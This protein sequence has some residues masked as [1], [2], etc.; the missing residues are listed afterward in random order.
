MRRDGSRNGRKRPAPFAR[1]RLRRCNPFTQEGRGE[2]LRFGDALHFDR[3]R[4]NR[5]LEAMEVVCRDARERL[6][7]LHA[8]REP[9]Q[10]PRAKRD[11]GKCGRHRD[12]NDCHLREQ[13]RIQLRRALL[14]SAGLPPYGVR[15]HKVARQSQAE[16][17]YKPRCGLPPKFTSVGEAQCGEIWQKLVSRH[18]QFVF[19][20]NGYVLNSGIGHVQ[21]QG[22]GDRTVHQLLVNYQCGVTPDRKNGGGGFLR[23]LEVEADGTVNVSDYSPFYDQWLT[24]PD[25]KFTIRLDRNLNTAP[26]A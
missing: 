20:F 8:A 11:A 3:N 14:S 4:V 18:P 1:I 16:R 26:G 13:Y 21:S 19:T 9:P 5:G 6:A 10:Y 24:E 23:L 7:R 17:F 2:A 15:K 22:A 25:R 12:D